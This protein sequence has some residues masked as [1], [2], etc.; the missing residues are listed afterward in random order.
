M[1]QMILDGEPHPALGHRLLTLGVGSR[2]ISRCRKINPVYF[3]QLSYFMHYKETFIFH[4]KLSGKFLY[5][6]RRKLS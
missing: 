4:L 3:K 2:I 5:H 1:G 6:R